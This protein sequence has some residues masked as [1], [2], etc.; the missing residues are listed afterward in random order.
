[1]VNEDEFD[2][3][4]AFAW[5]GER[6]DLLDQRRLPAETVWVECVDA[7]AVAEAIRS[8]VVRGAPAI[9]I[10]AAYGL[11]LAALR[12]EDLQQAAA[13]LGRARPTAI[14]L[15]WAIERMTA[16]AA[17]VSPGERPAR[18][19]REACAIHQE[20]L[21][22]N[23]ALGALGAGQIAGPTGVLTHCNTGAL[24]TGGFGTALGVIRAGWAEGR[25]DCVYMGETR[26]WLQGARLT[27][28]ELGREGI[29]A[30]LIVDS[31]AAALLASG[32]IGQVVV[33]ADR[34]AAN[35]D[36]ANK[37][38]TY[39]L[40]LLARAHGVPF[41]VAIPASTIDP[42]TPDGRAIP[43]ETR[44]ED[45][46]LAWAGRRVAPPGAR[47]WNPVFDITPA[48]LVD[49]LVTEHGVLRHPDRTGIAGLPAGCERAVDTPADAP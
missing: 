29:E 14:N 35:G 31:A 6:L 42:A 13:T 34:V 32:R 45:E 43:I 2:S 3:V 15:H 33:G 30:R 46:V 4:R 27:A 19:V 44:P 8:M 1:M 23:R 28:W 40:A 26:P 36:V 38:G 25:I 47:A 12:G 21:A 39:G 17:Q 18:L 16:V 11:A 22:A 24:A 37:I 49:A 5:R 10:A 20:D 48:H 9:G 7:S 41:M